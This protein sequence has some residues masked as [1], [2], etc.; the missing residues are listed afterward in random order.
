M[1]EDAPPLAAR[2]SRRA[3]ANSQYRS[4]AP[5]GSTGNPTGSGHWQG[6]AEASLEEL[7]VLV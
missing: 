5:T 3:V 2:R 1:E 6:P 7:L 4:T